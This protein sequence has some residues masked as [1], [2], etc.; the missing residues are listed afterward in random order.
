MMVPG[1]MVPCR[2]GVPCASV[3][4]LI[5]RLGGGTAAGDGVGQAQRVSLATGRKGWVAR[6]NTSSRPESN[7]LSSFLQTYVFTDEEDDA[8][9]RTM[10]NDLSYNTTFPSLLS[11]SEVSLPWEDVWHP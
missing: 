10:G 11:A 4:L 8:L 3:P 5:W 9:K 6:S 1:R 7:L 2:N